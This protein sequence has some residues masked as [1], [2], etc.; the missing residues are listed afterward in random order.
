MSEN[1]DRPTGRMQVDAEIPVQAAIVE[2]SNDAIVGISLDG[3]VETWNKAAEQLYGYSREE[4]IGLSMAGILPDDYL[5]KAASLF[6]Q[7]RNGREVAPVE[8]M[9]MR[10]DDSCA[11]ISLA[12]S[13]VRDAAGRLLGFSSIARDISVRVHAERAAAHLVAI[14]NSS[15]DAIISKTING[16]IQTWNSGAERLYGYT[17][18]EVLGRSMSILLPKN[19]LQEENDIL[20]KVRRG[21]RI[22]HFDTVRIHKDGRPVEVSLTVSPIHSSTGDLIGVSHV[23]RDISETRQLKEK[24]QISQKMEALGRLAGGIAH[25]FNNL[26]TVISGYGA[27]LQA[28]LNNDPKCSDMID[29]VMGAAEKAAELTRQLLVFSRNQ[30]A[31]FR[32]VDLNEEIRKLH[33]MLRRLI[34]EDISIETRLSPHL[35]KVRAD[36]GQI[37]QILMNLAANARDAMPQGGK[38]VIHTGNWIITEDR[39]HQQLGFTPGNYVR[40]LFSDTGHGM[41][42]ALRA[43]IFEPFFTTKEVGKGTGL[44]LATVYGIVKQ[45]GGQVSVYSEPGCGT[46]F[47]IYL[48]CAEADQPV[49]TVAA[50]EVK[51]GYETILLVEDEPSVRQLACSI[52]RTHGYTVL[53][54]GNAEE[55]LAQASRH[56]EGIRL[57]IT[58][59]VMPGTNGH[60]L[61]SR[62]SAQRSD[63]RVVFMSGYS[64][65]AILER[66]LAE[67]GA[68]FLQK[69]F[70]PAQLLRTVRDVLD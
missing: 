27:L 56:F 3:F 66:I 42:A 18:A 28:V 40:L 16:V 64:E 61:A 48:P 49:E 37:G 68:A 65:H 23:A 5:E 1:Q 4:M 41:D 7:I 45:S 50:A 22:D 58:D 44:G 62:L 24:L 25:D 14:I 39:F 31:H 30:V 47:A 15:D 59:I 46:T 9:V 34:G 33:G 12:I 54:A 10:K 52:L 21:E 32:A 57:L 35:E 11:H 67:P 51:H 17:A 63:L 19:L 69:P 36:P 8:T 29:E 53:T 43:R 38:I 13:P 2:S 6:E 55:A 70:T 20:L 60:E 26:L